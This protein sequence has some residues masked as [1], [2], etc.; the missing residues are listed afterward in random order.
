VA[1]VA[2][3][4]PF[5][6]ENLERGAAWLKRN[7]FDPVWDERCLSRHRYL[8]GEDAARAKALSDAILRDDVRGIFCARGGY[9]A[10]RLLQHLDAF[11]LKPHCKV[12]VGFSDVTTLHQ[13][14]MER[15]GWVTFHGPM[16]ATRWAGEGFDEETAV[17][18]LGAVTSADAPPPISGGKTLH[19]GRAQ[20]PL[21]G[22]NLSLICT[23]IGTS[24]EVNTDGT[25]LLLEDVH[26]APYR[27]DRMLTHLRQAGKLSGVRGIIVGEMLDCAAEGFTVNDVIADCLADVGVPVVTDFP[28]SHGK[29]NYTVALGLPH[30]LDADAGILT[31]LESGVV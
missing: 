16:V 20:G 9:G 6:P 7:G 17:S 23:S 22:G 12:F 26:E 29:P 1:I 13:Y 11:T 3:S 27:V 21:V 31:P 28:I 2:P 5:E 19:G 25:L 30:D 10:A 8:A 4:S 18:L 24:H 14:F 15:C